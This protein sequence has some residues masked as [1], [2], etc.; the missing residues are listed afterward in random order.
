MIPCSAF[1]NPRQ[2]SSRK[3]TGSRPSWGSSLAGDGADSQREE[4]ALLQLGA[5]LRER[6]T[7]D[8]PAAQHGGVELDRVHG[9][10]DGELGHRGIEL[11]LDALKQDGMEDTRLVNLPAQ[12]TVSEHELQPPTFPLQTPVESVQF[13]EQPAGGQGRP[14]VLGPRFTESPPRV[15]R[16][17]P[18]Q[19][20]FEALHYHALFSGAVLHRDV[21]RLEPLELFRRIPARST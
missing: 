11:K 18:R 6:A 17:R 10:R 8:T 7:V 15:Q 21:P 13:L 5:S 3:S 1:A 19:V 14:L 20:I 9:I 4:A 2:R 16:R 12:K